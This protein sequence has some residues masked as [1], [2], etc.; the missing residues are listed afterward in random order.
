VCVTHANLLNPARSHADERG[1]Q[2]DLT[3]SDP[4]TRE[5]TREV[6]RGDLHR[7]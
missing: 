6:L 7:R 2:Q 3:P 4:I 1:T 5:F